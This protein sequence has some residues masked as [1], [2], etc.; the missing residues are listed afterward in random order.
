MRRFLTIAIT[1]MALAGCASTASVPPSLLTGMP[2]PVS[3]ARDPAATESAA[4]LYIIDLAEA[5]ADCRSKLGEVHR[6]LTETN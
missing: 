2:H 4:S 3:P 1:A 5:G 6:L